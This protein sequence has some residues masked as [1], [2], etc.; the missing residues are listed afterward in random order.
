[1]TTS[2]EQ[3][4]AF[5]AGET[6]SVKGA[7][8]KGKKRKFTESIELQITLKN[9]DPQRDKRFSGTF[10]LPIIPKANSTVCVLGNQKHCEKADQI[11][12]DKMTVT[13]TTHKNTHAR[14]QT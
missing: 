10:R 14:T 2:V 7:D 6:I 9:Y 12:I 3:I 8:V 4:L 11:G 13:Y 1:L 5:A